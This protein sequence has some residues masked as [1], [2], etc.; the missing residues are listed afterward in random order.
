MVVEKQ[1]GR[2]L[3]FVSENLKRNRKIVVDVENQSYMVITGQLTCFH[4][5]RGNLPLR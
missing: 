2:L 1:N 5:G 4:H 3:Q